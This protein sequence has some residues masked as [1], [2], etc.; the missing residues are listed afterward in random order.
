[1]CVTMPDMIMSLRAAFSRE[2]PQTLQRSSKGDATHSQKPQVSI[3][4]IILR[5]DGRQT[6][7]VG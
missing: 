2:M 6:H 7:W 1:M 4:M 5:G 3:A